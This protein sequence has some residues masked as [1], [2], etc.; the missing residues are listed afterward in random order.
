MTTRCPCASGE[1]R[2]PGIS[3]RKQDTRT[4]RQS[5][6]TSETERLDP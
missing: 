2:T 4:S 5:D 3:H 1:D 6:M